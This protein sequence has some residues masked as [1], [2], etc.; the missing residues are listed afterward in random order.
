MTCAQTGSGK[1]AAFLCPVGMA[2]DPKEGC[3]H[4]FETW[5]GPA[6]PLCLVLAPTREL[7]AQIYTEA[8]KLF[9]RSSFKVALFNIDLKSI[10]L[11]LLPAGARISN[12][13]AM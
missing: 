3:E 9:H 11:I 7:C 6:E 2:L 5:E 1:T 10:L 13:M 8:R 12:N 4:R